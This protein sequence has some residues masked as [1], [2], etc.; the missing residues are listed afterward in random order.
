MPRV[1]SPL[2]RQ[3]VKL[4]WFGWGYW[5]LVAS[6]TPS[7][8]LRLRWLVRFLRVD[9]NLCHAHSPAEVS[10]VCLALA[11]RPSRHGEVM[12]EAGCWLGG[13][14]AKF[15]IACADLGYEL[16]VFD[17]FQGV[18]H[19]SHE[20]IGG[21][22]DFSGEYAATENVVRANVAA[23]GE[24]AVCR[25]HA[26]WFADTIAPVRLPFPVRIAYIDC[27]LAKGTLEVLTGTL[28][29][30]SDDGVI[31][32][33]DYHIESVRRL[34]HEQRTWSAL[35][36]TQPAI[37]SLGRRLAAIRFAEGEPSSRPPMWQ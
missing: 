21:G 9:W 10:R 35:G 6:R 37:V 18:E 30:L 3:R 27:D 15:S 17:S 32:S 31:F 14:S 33:Q 5:R 19:G 22:H 7:L 1:H 4:L 16:R 29:V 25:F 28:P 12:L 2:A 24:L 34:L 23:F 26:G 11:D 20:A 36:R 8:R 13:S